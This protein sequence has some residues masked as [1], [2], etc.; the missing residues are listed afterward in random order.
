MWKDTLATTWI[1]GRWNRGLERRVRYLVEV[2]FGNILGLEFGDELL[3]LCRQASAGLA[4]S[5]KLF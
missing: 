2:R 5:E 3:L 1:E 4:S